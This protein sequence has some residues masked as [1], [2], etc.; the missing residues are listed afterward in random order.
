MKP[1]ISVL[2]TVYNLA[3]YL[4]AAIESLRKQTLR[5]F[6][7]VVVENGSTDG[8]KD[9][10]RPLTQGLN[11]KL[12]DLKDNIGRVPALNV[13]MK[14]AEGD[15]VAILDADDIAHPR[16]F[17]TQVALL[18]SRPHVMMVSS[19]VRTIDETGQVTGHYTVPLDTRTL[20]DAMAYMNPFWHSACTF[21]RGDAIAVGGHDRRYPTAN[22]LALWIALSRRGELAVIPE[23]L[24]DIR[25]H[26]SNMT[27]ALPYAIS[28]F[29]EELDL[30]KL[31]QTLPGISSE[32]KRQGREA[33]AR[34]HF[35]IAKRFFRSGHPV[36]AAAE[37]VKCVFSAPTFVVR[38][39]AQRQPD[40]H[41][42]AA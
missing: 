38:Q 13:A 3:P 19:Y 21:R 30:Y 40:S 34:L 15:Y 11:V 41:S 42:A 24:A 12:I 10:I 1:R 27:N 37:L 39:M 2:M 22:D 4:Q 16:R 18:D 32:A 6:E 20:H 31:A 14:E 35:N 5:D 25:S 36:Q 7:L 9:I 17:E 28:R 29:N 8:G 26:A 23:E 33:I